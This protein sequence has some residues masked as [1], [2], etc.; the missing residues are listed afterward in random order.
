MDAQKFYNAIAIVAGLVV[1]GA[2]GVGYYGAHLGTSSRPGA[3]VAS[4]SGANGPGQAVYLT[5]NMNPVTG[6][7]QYT[8][9]NF[10]VGT[11]D[12]TIILT[13]YDMVNAW[14]GC[15]C[16]VTGTVGGT[17]LLNNTP[18][19]EV[20]PSNVAHTFTITSMNVNVPSPGMSTVEFTID[21]TQAGVVDWQCMV[22]W[23]AGSSPY[24]SPPMGL[25]GYMAG[26][27]TVS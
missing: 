25:A 24:G 4:A 17:E 10:T 16:K 18:V 1:I 12:V 22:P 8:P 7:P 23:G 6:W 13:D 20:S 26:E 14:S 21:F 11:G 15:M 3:S 5:I 27:I 19:S 9:A 2:F